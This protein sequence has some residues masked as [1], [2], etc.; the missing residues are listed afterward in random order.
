MCALGHGGAPAAEPA[1]DPSPA[2]LRVAFWGSELSRDGPGLLLRDIAERDADV[3]A[4]A[5]LIAGAAPD[6][7]ALSGFDRDEGGLALAAFATLIAEAGHPMPHLTAPQT[8]AGRPT[9]RDLDGRGWLD[10]DDAHGWGRFEGEGGLALLSRLPLE[11]LDDFTALAWDDLPGAPG[12]EITFGVR[13]SSTSHAI[14]SAGP[15]TLVLWG[16]TP[17]VFDGPED[18]NGIR[19]GD[20]AR[21]WS[22]WLD[23]AIGAVPEGPLVLMGRSNIDPYDG[24]GD[25]ADMRALLRHPRLQDAGPV[26][27]DWPEQPAHAGDPALDT[28]R[29]DGP[30]ALRVDYLLPSRDLAVLDGGLIW[31]SSPS[32]SRHALLWLDLLVEPAATG[33]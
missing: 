31:P 24:D 22:L 14:Y 23:G 1:P 15:L 32:E 7:I 30:G 8:N 9:G 13:L 19:G 29:F 3:L 20:E 21:L 12:P 26:G 4:A 11:P 17:P 5:S 16:A 33:R 28:A 2:R 27:T 18:R 25:H 10:A 6:V